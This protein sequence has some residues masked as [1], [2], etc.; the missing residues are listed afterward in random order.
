MARRTAR[1]SSGAIVEP[2]TCANQSASG[3]FGHAPPY[4]FLVCSDRVFAEWQDLQRRWRFSRTRRKSAFS[5]M[6]TMWSVC[7]PGRMRPAA[8]HVR[9]SGSSAA[10]MRESRSQVPSYHS[11]RFV[12]RIR[13][14]AREGMEAT[15]ADVPRA[16]RAGG[17]FFMVGKRTAGV[18][19]ILDEKCSLV[20][21]RGFR[22]G[23]QPSFFS[24]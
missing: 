21:P 7:S 16:N 9:Q 12:A 1:P 3:W 15:G 5:A 6:G 17:W 18:A 11:R 24:K 20:N 2:A 19:N 22:P 10:T 4:H 8:R 23:C 13:R 14:S